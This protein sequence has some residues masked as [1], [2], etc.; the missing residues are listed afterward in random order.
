MNRSMASKVGYSILPICRMLQRSKP[1][2]APTAQQPPDSSSKMAMI[3]HHCSGNAVTNRAL[4]VLRSQHQRKIL[5]RYPVQAHP[6]TASAWS[7][8]GS[9]PTFLTSGREPSLVTRATRELNSFFCDFAIATYLFRI[10]RFYASILPCVPL[11]MFFDI[12]H[13][14]ASRQIC[15]ECFYRKRRAV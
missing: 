5:C 15:I 14:V 2:I 9:S 12:Q 11:A 4:A 3:D 7:F 6:L 13:I 10:A 8:F 1:R